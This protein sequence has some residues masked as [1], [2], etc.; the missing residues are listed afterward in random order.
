MDYFMNEL[1]KIYQTKEEYIEECK[2]CFMRQSKEIQEEI[3]NASTEELEQELKVTNF[4]V[5]EELRK[6]MKYEL[7]LR[8]DF[9]EEI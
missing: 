2:Q 6:A 5:F 9:E 7:M 8:N 3:E 4:S 1:A